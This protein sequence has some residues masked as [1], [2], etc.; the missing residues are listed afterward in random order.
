[1]QYICLVLAFISVSFLAYW[2]PLL[3]SFN[4]KCSP[5]YQKKTINFAYSKQVNYSS[6]LRNTYY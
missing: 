2:N 1:M 5:Y 3:K 6:N 4:V